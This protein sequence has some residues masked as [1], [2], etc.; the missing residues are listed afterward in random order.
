VWFWICLF[1]LLLGFI[2][3]TFVG[4]LLITSWEVKYQRD[5]ERHVDDQIGRLDDDE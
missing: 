5:L 2:I 3:G 1:F 4:A